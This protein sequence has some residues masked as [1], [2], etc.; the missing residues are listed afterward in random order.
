[1]LILFLILFNFP[2]LDVI[3]F[4]FVIIFPRLDATAFSF[5]PIFPKEL[6]NVDILFCIPLIIFLFLLIFN[7]IAANCNF[8]FVSSKEFL[9]LY[10]IYHSYFIYIN[11]W[12]VVKIKIL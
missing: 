6:L 10:N 9:S 7:D 12:I 3:S 11:I 8:Y 5:V 2:K 1:M 4:L